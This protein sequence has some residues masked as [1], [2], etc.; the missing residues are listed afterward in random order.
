MGF[1]PPPGGGAGAHRPAQDAVVI[2]DGLGVTREH[3]RLGPAVDV[4]QD[5][6]LG[7]ER[8]SACDPGVAGCGQRPDAVAEGLDRYADLLPGLGL[9]ERARAS[10]RG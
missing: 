9:A 10:A 3:P 2:A 5:E 6:Q 1:E 7:A 4:E 8:P